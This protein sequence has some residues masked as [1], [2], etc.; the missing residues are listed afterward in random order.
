MTIIKEKKCVSSGDSIVFYVFLKQPSTMEQRQIF[1][2]KNGII[3]PKLSIT[4]K[5]PCI[6]LNVQWQR[7]QN[8]VE[9]ASEI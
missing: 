7:R 6:V 1:D 4:F 5:A 3:L 2:K 9:I 8:S